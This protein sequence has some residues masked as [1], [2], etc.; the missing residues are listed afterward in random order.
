MSE[1]INQN[2]EDMDDDVLSPYETNTETESSAI[3]ETDTNESVEVDADAD[4]AV[5]VKADSKT[6]VLYTTKEL[7]GYSDDKLIELLR[8]SWGYKVGEPFEVFGILKIKNTFLV[9]ENLWNKNWER[10]SYPLKDQSFEQ[11]VFAGPIRRDF[12]EGDLVKTMVTLS[13]S[14]KRKNRNNPFALATIPS[15]MVK[16]IEAPDE[17]LKQGIYQ[18]KGYIERWVVDF[19]ASKQAD[20]IKSEVN[21]SV[22]KL[23]AEKR[24]SENLLAE[25]NAGLNESQ[26][27]FQKNVE[28]IERQN[29]ILEEK[30]TLIA[31][32][33]NELSQIIQNKE[34]VVSKLNEFIE[35]KAKLLRDLDIVDE[36]VLNQLT[37]KG[38]SIQD[39][40]DGHN[41]SELFGDIKNGIGYI[42]AYLYNKGIMYRR[43]VLEN[44]FT[45]LSTR[46]LIIL[47]GDSGSGKTNLV[48]SFAEAIGGKSIIIPV[49][50]NWT[51]SEDL[52]GYYN[53]IEHNY[54]STLFLDAL[55][56]AK[57]N[58]EIPYL[59]CLDEMN[60][61]RVEYYF[62]DF[63]SLLEERKQQPVVHL[64]SQSES[65]HLVSETKNFLALLDEAKENLHK[66]NLDSF[67][68]ILQDEEL[69]R[70]LHEL[71]GFK[72]GDS[73]L[74]YHTRL[75]KSFASYLSN[76]ATIEIPKNVFFIGAINIDETTHYLSPKILDRAHIMRFTNPLLQDWEDINVQIQDYENVDLSK[77]V[78]FTIENFGG[79]KEYPRFE[80]E[81]ELE[82]ALIHMTKEYLIP[83]GV[84]F[85]LRSIRQASNYM[86]CY[87]EHFDI[88]QKEILNHV[89]RQKILPKLMFDGTKKILGDKDRKD[90]L[91]DMKSYLTS[92]LSDL[93]ISVD[94]NVIEDLNRTLNNAEINDWVVNYWFK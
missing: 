68:E 29:S 42:Q 49:K 62:A 8:K 19:I 86:H 71:C 78:L 17:I 63:L 77:P 28:I 9:V 93:D 1:E 66:E 37:G 14:I 54:L 56:E 55:L 44:F 33:R 61:A 40:R 5:M 75:R 73:L 25:V 50:P 47:A 24:D 30:Q 65:S 34:E 3:T 74:K 36:Q 45:L 4:A 60:L 57:N 43:E 89:V 80:M 46:D 84:E 58:P 48:K 39:T 53:P 76:P 32:A 15:S 94:D 26:E 79:R 27:K 82:Q 16:L 22:Q 10:V 67:V 70:K 88:T 90:V 92:E 20:K 81:G 72:D 87:Q 52:L 31:E 41:L 91:L 38:Q 69:N 12:T 6:V 13:P 21:N 64:Y 2:M 51:G 59:I 85:G 23:F 18:D 83:L 7:Q 35:V 11:G